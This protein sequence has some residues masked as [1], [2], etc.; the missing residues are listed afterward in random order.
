MDY[1]KKETYDNEDLN[2]NLEA[3]KPQIKGN[4][5]LHEPTEH[6]PVNPP[7]SELVKEQ[8]QFYDVNLDTVKEKAITA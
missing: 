6:Y 3:I 5:K 4:V 8:W 1:L 7:E 2:P